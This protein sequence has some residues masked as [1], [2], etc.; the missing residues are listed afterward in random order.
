VFKEQ[1]NGVNTRDFICLG[2]NAKGF[3][4]KSQTRTAVISIVFFNTFVFHDLCDEAGIIITDR[5]FLL[6]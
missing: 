3:L 4:D 1:N 5:A 2:N 6:R